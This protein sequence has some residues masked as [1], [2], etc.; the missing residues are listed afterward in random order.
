MKIQGKNSIKRKLEELI[1][2]CLL[3]SMEIYGK[4]PFVVKLCRKLILFG[5]QKNMKKTSNLCRTSQIFFNFQ[6]ILS[7]KTR[8]LKSMIFETS[9]TN[10][11]GGYVTRIEQMFLTL[12]YI[13]SIV[14][15]RKIHLEVT[16]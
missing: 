7:S 16:K 12:Y 5:K 13:Y 1:A 2:F 9:L 11:K 6:V 4:I 3:S 10:M 8:L 14:W 15:I